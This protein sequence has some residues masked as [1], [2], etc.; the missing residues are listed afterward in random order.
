MER[1]TRNSEREGRGTH[2]LRLV[3]KTGAQATLSGSGQA[4]GR[5]LMTPGCLVRGAVKVAEKS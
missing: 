1:G 3:E 4:R 2:M 5:S